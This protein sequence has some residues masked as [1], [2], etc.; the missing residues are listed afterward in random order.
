MNEF[1]PETEQRNVLRHLSEHDSLTRAD[2][3]IEL[4][5]DG[6]S[7]FTGA[8]DREPLETRF[9]H[10]LVL[11]LRNRR[12]YVTNDE[13]HWL[14]TPEDSERVDTHESRMLAFDP[15]RERRNVLRSIDTQS[16]PLLG[17]IHR[18]LVDMDRSVFRRMP[19]Q[20]WNEERHMMIPLRG[21][22]D[23]RGLITNDRGSNYQSWALTEAGRERLEERTG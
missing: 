9:V 6:D 10:R 18:G 13:Q 17:D 12:G 7:W 5:A 1:D 15:E 20:G 23:E 22:L 2:L 11:Y 16:E 8:K 14:L 4:A 19:P 3:H 21:S